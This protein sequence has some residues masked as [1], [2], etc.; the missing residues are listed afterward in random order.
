MLTVQVQT[1]GEMMKRG[2]AFLRE[3]AGAREVLVLA[4]AR[5]AADDLV[6]SACD[7]AAFGIHR[8]TLRDF[9]IA[10]GTE[11][12]NQRGLV[13][14]RR[15]AREALAA[16]VTARA[17]LK[18]F[19]PVAQYP[20]FPRALA[21]TLETVRLN[22]ITAEQL[23]A[24]GDQGVDLAL[25]LELYESE[26]HDRGLADHAVRVRLAAASPSPFTGL[27]LLLID[28]QDPPLLERE[29]L[30][31]LAANSPDS[32]ALSIGPGLDDPKNCLESLQRF[33]LSGEEVAHR[34][35]DSTFSIFSASG[36]SLESVEIARRVLAAARDG[37]PFDETAILLRNPQRYRSLIAEAL[38]RAGVPACFSRGARNPDPSGRAFVILL[39]CAAEN[40]SAARFAEY[41]SLGQTPAEE[42]QMRAPARWEKLLADA[43]VIGGKDRWARRLAGLLASSD[44]RYQAAM[45]EGERAYIA[46]QIDHLESLRGFALPLI[47]RL[48][49]LPRGGAWRDWLTALRE[50]ASASLRDPESVHDLLDELEP[51]SEIGPVS[52]DQVLLVLE[53][54]LTTSLAAPRSERYG[55]VFIADINDA[56]GM[57]FRC[58]FVPGLNEGIFPRPPVQDPLLLDEHREQLGVHSTAEDASLL[59]TACAC[60]SEQIVFSWSRLDLLTGRERVPSFYAFEVLKAARGTGI[61]VHALVSEALVGTETRVGW[62]APSDFAAAIDDLEYD[63]AYVRPAWNARTQGEA[64]YLRRV[65]P[66]AVRSLTTRWRRWKNAW[67]DADGFVD[68]DVHAL[69]VLDAH[70][71]S[72]RA[73]S[74]SALE[75]F[76]RCPYRFALRGIY[77]LRPQEPPEPLQCID[78]ATRGRIYHRIQFE[79]LRTRTPGANLACMLEQLE[80][81][82]RKVALELEEQFAPA[83][84]EVWRAGIESIHA[85]LRGWLVHRCKVEPGWKPLH[86]EFAYGMKETEGHDPASR[87]D[88]IEALP[89]VS[90]TGSIDLIEQNA[91]GELR[92]VDHKT[93]SFP[94][95]TVHMVGQGEYLQP[96]LYALAAE[97]ALG[98]RVDQARLFYATL[99][100]GYRSIDINVH[101]GARRSA[102]QVVS[103]IDEAL[104]E[105]FLPAAPRKDACR[106]C[107]YLVVCGPWEEE[108]VAKKPPRELVPLDRI[109]S[110]S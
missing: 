38:A 7:E 92:V 63:L 27:P 49:A 16:L 84:P 8:F 4:P 90:L 104:H 108:R 41:L 109:R 110:L 65:N 96:V 32:L 39:R 42:G 34:A 74:V 75:E 88:P 72:K 58:V 23:R 93:G 14:V 62:P 94:A 103:T 36:E 54:G 12:L 26:L 20:G 17:R 68:L 1:Y 79:L 73:W 15:I 10:A 66:H 85:D 78:P 28:I 99:R 44:D 81:I 89:G 105:G 107:D 60:A 11:A 50:L 106:H 64:A 80:A 98:V 30:E 95:K 83:V 6:R 22:G 91:N 9:V 5:A 48:E 18:Y 67:S 69:G 86:Y 46:A 97:A 76:A 102:E 24:L 21:S 82:V 51:M 37:V 29:L 52:L 56:R 53:N 25:L 57:S 70:R 61:D 59:R 43:A 55:S 33:V 100:Q 3:H 40:Y 101:A 47:G 35:P 77:G 45:T 2:A 13:P 19:A 71:P 31:Q 87:R